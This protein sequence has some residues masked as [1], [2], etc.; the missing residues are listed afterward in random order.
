MLVH[1]ARLSYYT[2]LP[3][4]CLTVRALLGAGPQGSTLSW[5]GRSF[6]YSTRELSCH[7]PQSLWTQILSPPSIFPS[8][9]LTHH[10][11]C[12]SSL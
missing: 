6:P 3:D 12:P 8:T 11:P 9:Y 7:T 5:H 10:V 2:V 4:L 1:G